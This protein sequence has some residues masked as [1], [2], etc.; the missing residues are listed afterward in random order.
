MRRLSTLLAVTAV[1]TLV[2]VDDAWSARTGGRG[3]ARAG[4][5]GGGASRPGFAMH[6]HRGR[7]VFF[8]G[9][10]FL[11]WSWPYG[12]YYAPPPY[13]Y[14]PDYVARETLPPV[15]VEKFDG[16]PTPQTAGDIYCPDSQAY[17]PDVQEC[18]NGWQR[19][20]REPVVTLTPN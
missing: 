18:P 10:P 1:L 7:A 20:I 11:F 17:Y 15:Y 19:I 14:G 6:H 4:F 5:A 2:A 16:A 9:A 3:G 13:Y 8:V 12:Y